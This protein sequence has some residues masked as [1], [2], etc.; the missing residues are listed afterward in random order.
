MTAPRTTTD[1][2]TRRTAPRSTSGAATIRPAA[3]RRFPF[4]FVGPFELAARAVGVTPEGAAVEVDDDHLL[5]CF[6]PWTVETPLDN[7][8]GVA[9]TGPYAWPKVIGPPHLSLK[10]RGLTFGTNPSRGVCI[11][12]REPVRGIDPFG[13]IRHPGLTVTVD[14]VEG[15]IQHLREEGARRTDLEE[16]REVQHVHDRLHGMTAA[17]LR[18]L[19]DE[20]GIAHASAKKKA[21]LV[22]L[23]ERELSDEQMAEDVEEID[24]REG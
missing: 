24:L 12:F 22:E 15:L 6:G 13:L 20:H 2:G 18:E 21:D 23:L 7:V 8:A 17:Q 3:P 9:L 10:D 4:R 14:D 5:V 11:T 1:P 19:A 16:Q